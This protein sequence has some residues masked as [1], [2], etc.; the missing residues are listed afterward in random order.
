MLV[1]AAG[2]PGPIP[3]ADG[4]LICPV[5]EP[6]S[7]LIVDVDDRHHPQL[8]RWARSRRDQYEQANWFAPGIST[9]TGRIERFLREEPPMSTSPFAPRSDEGSRSEAAKYYALRRARQV[10]TRQCGERCA[11]AEGERKFGA[12]T[13][14]RARSQRLQSADLR[15]RGALRVP[16]HRGDR[17]VVAATKGSATGVEG[18]GAFSAGPRAPPRSE[19]V[20]HA[21][22][23]DQ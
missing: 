8:R 21:G 16:R 13:G 14:R 15:G 11:A 19:P 10:G 3:I 17:D 12:G 1:W 7:L 22:D 5:E 23:R 2:G 9:T 6:R 18:R 20:A 4:S